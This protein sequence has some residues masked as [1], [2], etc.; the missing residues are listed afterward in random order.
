LP[1]LAHTFGTGSILSRRARAAQ[2]LFLSRDTVTGVVGSARDYVTK[3]LLE[4]ERFTAIIDS[5]RFKGRP[6]RTLGPADELLAKVWTHVDWAAWRV[7]IPG[8]RVAGS[9]PQPL[10]LT[11]DRRVL[12]DSAFDESQVAANPLMKARLPRARRVPGRLL[13]LVGLFGREWYHWLLEVL[14]RTALLPLDDD[15][16]ADVLVPAN[17]SR[18]QGQS[19]TLAGVSPER[20]R[21]YKGGHITADELVFPSLVAPSGNP[22]RWALRW[23]REHLAPA[24]QRHDRR[25]YVSRADAAERRIVN[26]S[27]VTVL[28]RERGFE[29]VIGSELALSEQLRRFAEAEV[30]LG[31]HGGGLANL[32]ATTTA[33]VIELHG[34]GVARPCYFAQANAQGLEYWYL[35]CEPAGPVDLRVDLLELE[36]TLDAAGVT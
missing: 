6:G 27:E 9:Q 28:L 29:T 3:E 25:L 21:P 8:G 7:S 4:P 11:H 22:A 2:R 14:P 26:E 12:A 23:L 5:E 33:T 1:T 31:A 17:L 18:A 34:G 36:R 15:R 16:Q 10:V 30:V 19:L 24:P 32:C 20:R 13:V 35:R